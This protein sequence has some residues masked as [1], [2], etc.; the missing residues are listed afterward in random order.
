MDL[1]TGASYCQQGSLRL[2]APTGCAM[3]G[4]SKSDSRYVSMTNHIPPSRVTAVL[5]PH[6]R[7]LMSACIGSYVHCGI[8]LHS[9]CTI[10]FKEMLLKLTVIVEP[11]CHYLMMSFTNCQGRLRGECSSN[12][13]SKC[14][15][16]LIHSLDRLRGEYFSNLCV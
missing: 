5:L 12:L 11:L 8:P 2:A 1:A 14:K 9:Y 3:L 15:S 10:F 7:I 13:V 4:P 16:S 6:I